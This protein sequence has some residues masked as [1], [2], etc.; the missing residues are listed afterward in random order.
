[1]AKIYFDK[2]EL[3]ITRRGLNKLT[4]EELAKVSKASKKTEKSW[5]EQ[6]GPV[7]KIMAFMNKYQIYRPYKYV[8]PKQLNIYGHLIG[9][10]FL[11]KSKSVTRKISASMRAFFP[12]ASSRRIKQLTD[13]SVKYLG[14]VF[15]D[16]MFG[17][18]Q[19]TIPPYD[20]LYQYEN[21][22][23]LDKAVAE[24]K[25]VILC[26]THVGSFLQ[27]M[28]G[29]SLHKNQYW[30]T[31][32][33]NLSNSIF[34]QYLIAKPDFKRLYVYPT[35]SFQIIGKMLEKRLKENHI[36]I[37][38]A[39]YSM[40][41]HLRVPYLEGKSPFL[42][43]TV[44]SAVSLHRKTGAPI[45]PCMSY[46][47]GSNGKT[48]FRI[49]D[50]TKI[51]EASKKYW[52]APKKEFHGRISMEINRIMYPEIRK[53]A[54]TWEEIMNFAYLRL[55][56][57]LQIP[58]NT[59]MK[60]FLELV[61]QKMGQIIDGSFEPDRPDEKYLQLLTEYGPKIISALHSPEK[62][63]RPHRCKVNLSLMDAHSELM[64]L[65]RVIHNALEM[66]GEN[67]AL[68]IEN[69]FVMKLNMIEMK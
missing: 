12:N 8:P 37:I 59:S 68:S 48:R 3:N 47:N 67:D 15:V 16:F 28:P 22:E 9:K 34:Y 19:T 10:F 69:E 5:V 11:G 53:C 65:C 42:I 7:F 56:D 54:H 1:M 29:F 51:M 21:L 62:V 36:V 44:Q 27:T 38:Y 2:K 39:D 18:P 60:Q 66:N 43:H 24:K 57:K 52:N 33:A 20:R 4:P 30:V 25:G 31:G 17:L 26:V 49:M 23:I 46:P 35:I 58:A 61:G 40:K 6:I 55:A 14:M 41:D 50:N 45:I 63:F 13:A 64:K 32:V